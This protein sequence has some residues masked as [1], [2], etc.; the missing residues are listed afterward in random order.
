MNTKNENNQ[1]NFDDFCK[2]ISFIVMQSSKTYCFMSG[3]LL[4]KVFLPSV[5]V[6]YSGGFL[7]GSG[8]FDGL[9]SFGLFASEV[10]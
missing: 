2:A 4:S 8:A 5:G 10:I 9:G 3:S 7:R 6:L 1:I